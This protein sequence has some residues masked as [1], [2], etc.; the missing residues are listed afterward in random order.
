MVRIV[1][2][3]SGGSNCAWR[4]PQTFPTRKG[5]YTSLRHIPLLK[6][7]SGMRCHPKQA[8]GIAISGFSKLCL[9]AGAELPHSSYIQ[10]WVLLQIVWLIW[11]IYAASLPS[12]GAAVDHFS[13][14]RTPFR[15]AIIAIHIRPISKAGLCPIY[16]GWRFNVKR[17]GD[18]AIFTCLDLHGWVD[19]RA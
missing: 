7:I 13:A 3:A 4:A 5:A 17:V 15:M 9:R 6:L 19:L 11:W 18:N 1:A 16:S 12:R 2:G 14:P 10:F 8:L